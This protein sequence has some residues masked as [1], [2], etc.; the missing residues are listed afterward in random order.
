MVSK[1]MERMHEAD[2]GCIMFT[3]RLVSMGM[4][5]AIW[6]HFYCV[7]FGQIRA[8]LTVWFGMDL[9]VTDLF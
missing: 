7:H 3:R 1:A 6:H 2:K 4:P 8:C 5:L 9:M